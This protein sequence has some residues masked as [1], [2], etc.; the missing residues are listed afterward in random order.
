MT[1]IDDAREKVAAG[2]IKMAGDGSVPAASAALKLLNEIEQ[3]EASQRHRERLDELRDDPPSL[4]AYLGELGQDDDAVA[5]IIG[6]AMSADE[7]A[8]WA[9][10]K[11]DRAVEV[12]ALEL[13][14]ARK[15]GK[16]DGWM[17]RR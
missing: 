9:R 2:L 17:R 14:A 5:A 8:A 3:T 13:A 1:W 4:C 12:R 6:R 15:G 7:S 16:V 11:L 10:G